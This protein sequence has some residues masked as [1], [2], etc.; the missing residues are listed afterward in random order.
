MKFILKEKPNLIIFQDVRFYHYFQKIKTLQ[1]SC[2]FK[3]IYDA[4]NVEGKLFNDIYHSSERKQSLFFISKFDPSKVLPIKIKR[5]EQRFVREA[6]QVWVCSENDANLMREMYGQNLSIQVVPN[7]I[8]VHDY[9]HLRLGK[10]PLP[11]NW[12]FIPHTIVFPATFGYQPNSV[13]AKLLI[14]EIYPRLQKIYS[15]SRLI[16][17]GSGPTKL[18]RETAKSNPNIIVTGKVPDIKPYLAA[19]N[20]MVVPLQEGGGT[21]LKILE[22]FAAGIPVVSTSKGAEGLKAQ[23][24]QHLLIRDTM[25]DIVEGII[26]LW[27]DPCFAKKLADNAYKLVQFEYSWEA[28]GDRVKAIIFPS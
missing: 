24:E 20:V 16:L 23:D 10:C 22:A 27:S 28:V 19:G 2:Q 1:E 9:E 25:E 6:N 14:E 4:Q 12:K 13:A 7:G 15:D 11:E 18:M 21:R 8:N 5:I 17:V 3:V 26:Q